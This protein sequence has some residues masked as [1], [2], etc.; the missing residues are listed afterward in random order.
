M[1]FKHLI[2]LILVIGLPTLFASLPFDGRDGYHIGPKVTDKIGFWGATP[3]VQP[4]SANQAAVASTP[5]ATI[6]PTTTPVGSAVNPTI[7]QVNALT[8]LVN[9]MRA[10]LVAQGLLK[11]GP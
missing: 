8:V 4:A 3:V 1:K 7:T 5:V 10:D 2:I 11:G 9:Q 6:T